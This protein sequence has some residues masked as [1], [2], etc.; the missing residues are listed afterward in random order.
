MH[1]VQSLCVE[2]I[3]WVKAQVSLRSHC[4]NYNPSCSVKFGDS[5]WLLPGLG[6]TE[7]ATNYT[8]Q[9][10][11]QNPFTKYPNTQ[12]RYKA[13]RE[14]TSSIYGAAGTKNIPWNAPLTASLSVEKCLDFLM[15]AR[16]PWSP[17]ELEVNSYHMETR[18]KHTYSAWPLPHL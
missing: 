8:H 1:C 7:L 3:N 13:D 12:M 18:S 5:C 6:N 4:Q 17:L 14:N 2:A 15:R 9:R 11:T 10:Y 16:S